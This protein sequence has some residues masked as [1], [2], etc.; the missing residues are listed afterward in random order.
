[1]KS[2]RCSP[3]I[4]TKL[5]TVLFITFWKY[6]PV[7]VPY[8]CWEY[9]LPTCSNNTVAW[10]IQLLIAIIFYSSFPVRRLTFGSFLAVMVNVLP[11]T[12]IYFS[13]QG[14]KTRSHAK[15]AVLS[16]TT[17]WKITE[18]KHLQWEY[19]MW[20]DRRPRRSC[21]SLETTFP[22]KHQPLFPIFWANDSSN[23]GAQAIT[24]RPYWNQTRH[25]RN[26]TSP[27]CNPLK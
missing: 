2:S 20:L 12:V 3:W 11:A 26:N 13:Y 21:L 15:T 19:R 24:A 27:A 1:M 8:C 16:I 23:S 6:I 22:H 9:L 14:Q 7:K 25:C 10:L 17:V 18:I 5:N 4:G